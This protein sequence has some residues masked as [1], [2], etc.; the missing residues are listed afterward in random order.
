MARITGKKAIFFVTSPRTP[1]KM[2]EEIPVLISTVGGQPWNKTTQTQFYETLVEKDFFHGS[3][4]GALDFKARDRINRSPQGLGFVDLKPVVTLTKAGKSFIYG[5]RSSEV[6]LKQMLKF[7]FPSPFHMD[8][9][10]EFNVKPYL[11]LIR[12]IRDAK[13]LTKLEIAMFFMQLNHFNKYD[14]V[15]NELLAFRV[16]TKGRSRNVS[17]VTF[18]TE[19]FNTIILRQFADMIAEDTIATRESNETTLERFLYTKR[20]NHRDYSDAAIRYLRATGL[21]SF[22]PKRNRIMVNEE[23]AAEV[24][25]ICSS[26]PREAYAYANDQDYKDYLFSDSNVKLL[27][28]QRDYLLAQIQLYDPKAL[29]ALENVDIDILKDKLQEFQVRKMADVKN[30]EVQSLQRN[31][32]KY[33]DIIDIFDKISKKKII[34]SPLFFEWNAWR[35]FTMLNDGNIIGNFRIDDEGLPLYSA[36]GNMPDI[37]CNYADFNVVVEVTLSGGSRQYDMEG[38]PVARHL[39][40]IKKTTEGDAY[41]LFIAPKISPATLAH[42]FALHRLDIKYYGGKSKIIPVDLPDFITM[43]TNAHQAVNKPDAGAIKQFCVSVSETALSVSNEEEWMD[44]IR[45][46]TK[47]VF[48]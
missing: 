9:E 6:L 43:L 8:T 41:C 20:T 29:S 44:R 40:N 23:R 48:S 37:E 13:G 46:L 35:A 26:I 34:D 18:M 31:Y 15:K 39:G 4:T 25:Y 32:T 45:E 1:N 36:P 38:E 5:K 3:A 42:Y 7:Q 47:T 11:E 22:D 21:F 27:N 33:P 14:T 17:Y 2:L 24:D 30:R 28:D 16:K 10:G 19:N 12:L